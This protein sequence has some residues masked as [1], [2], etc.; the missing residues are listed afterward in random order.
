MARREPRRSLGP[1]FFA[2]PRK[3]AVPLHAE[4][5]QLSAAQLSPLSVRLATAHTVA[6]TSRCKPT[7]TVGPPTA[8]N[9]DLSQEI[10]LPQEAKRPRAV[11]SRMLSVAAELGQQGRA[12]AGN[13]ARAEGPSGQNRLCRAEEEAVFEKPL[14]WPNS[15]IVRMKTSDLGKP[16]TG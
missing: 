13:E 16:E 15:G 10:S 1:L 3:R 4:P 11:T 12:L 2:A 8:A 5:A 14:K 7:Q 6:P 9:S